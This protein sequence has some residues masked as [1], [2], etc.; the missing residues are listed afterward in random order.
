MKYKIF[1]GNSL[2]DYFNLNESFIISDYET[3]LKLVVNL[4]QSL[5]N[6]DFFR[7]KSLAIIIFFDGSL[8]KREINDLVIKEDKIIVSLKAISFST[9]DYRKHTFIIEIDKCNNQDYQII[10]KK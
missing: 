5:Y 4:K 2:D 7:E 8:P 9:M 10:L 1:N 6:K 3:Y